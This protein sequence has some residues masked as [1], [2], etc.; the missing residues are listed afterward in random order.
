MPASVTTENLGTPEMSNDVRRVVTA[1]FAE[2]SQDWTVSVLG[3]QS[4]NAWHVRVSNGQQIWTQDLHAVQHSAMAVL[5]SLKFV[6]W[7]A[8]S[9]LTSHQTDYR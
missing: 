4:S 1:F 9:N 3:S 7:Q 5:E 8:T 2:E 6:A